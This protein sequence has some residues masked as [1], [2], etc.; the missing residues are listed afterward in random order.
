[1]IGFVV[2]TY[3]ICSSYSFW[4]NLLIIL[5]FSVIFHCLKTG[6]VPCPGD[7][8]MVTGWTTRDSEYCWWFILVDG[9]VFWEKSGCHA[10]I[11]P[12]HDTIW[13]KMWSY[14]YLAWQFCQSNYSL[15]GLAHTNE[16]SYCSM[17]GHRLIISW[18]YLMIISHDHISWSCSAI[19]PHSDLPPNDAFSSSV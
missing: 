14:F 10:T 1:M 13:M 8:L 9:S 2:F 19:P 7:K 5:W 3:H 6:L 18:S 16:K 17:P 11:N 15:I 12:P 4:A